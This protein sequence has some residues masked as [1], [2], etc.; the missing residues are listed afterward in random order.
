M[1]LINVSSG[2]IIHSVNDSVKT[3]ELVIKG[4]ISIQ[5]S[6]Q[7]VFLEKGSLIGLFETPGENYTGTYTAE[8]DSCIYSYTY[9]DMES[10]QKV[11]TVN[12]KLSPMLAE[13]TVD[14][15]LDLYYA[16]DNFYR[17]LEVDYG[18][19]SG[20]LDD[21][22]VLAKR[23]D[24]NLKTFP[25]L[26][27][28]EGPE[29]D[30]LIRDWELNYLESLS[31]NKD[32]LLSSFYGLSVDIALGIII[33]LSLLSRDVLNAMKELALYQN[34]L[35]E[36][37][38]PFLMEE[39][40]VRARLNAMKNSKAPG[41]MDENGEVPL[42]KNAVDVILSYSGVNAE[43]VLKTKTDIAAF[44]NLNNRS[45]GN[46]E[47][48]KLRRELTDLFF[49]IYTPCFLKSHDDPMHTPAEVRMFLLF[50]FIDEEM[51]GADNTEMLYRIMQT[52]RPDPG[53]HVFTMYQWLGLVMD[54]IEKPS[55][56]EFEQDY[57]AYIRELHMRG[58]IDDK[59]YESRINDPR[60]R[61]S[62]EI[63]NL[64]K[65]GNKM[66]FGRMSTYQ[67]FFDRE[68]A[69]MGLERTYL[70]ASRIN[71][72]LEKLMSV[73]K[74]LFRIDEE[75]R[76]EELD[77]K[78]LGIYELVYPKI[79]LFPN[80][81]SRACLWQ[82]TG[83]KRRNTPA[84]FIMPIFL[85]EDL[86]KSLVSLLGEYRWEITKTIQGVHWNDIKDPSLT[87]DYNDYIQFYKKNRDLNQEQKEKIK[88]Q[89][90][91]AGGN[92][93]RTFVA[94]YCVYMNSESKGSPLLN[95]VVRSIFFTYC[96]FNKDIREKLK[97][98]PIYQ[99]ELNKF[100]TKTMERLRPIENTIK[101]LEHSGLEVPA[102]LTD[103][104]DFLLS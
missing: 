47:T 60:E 54:G 90:S 104:V 24:M 80:C 43:T 50:G 71:E 6:D 88:K 49:K 42:I 75:Y 93:R 16:Y 40:L 81:G 62:F 55:R 82:E 61:L 27:A 8:E 13:K 46:D 103:Q 87:S 37:E 52:Y 2:Q 72:T 99:A 38:K 65:M 95:K 74:F 7:K 4:K 67:P 51:A 79:I 59:E 76:N 36:V 102:I 3:I 31:S 10:L 78:A 66:T 26:S 45:S 89:I 1:G 23:A 73:D 29:R 58:E 63:A 48:R 18:K 30:E 32:S 77:I 21:Y 11:V 9:E 33:Q 28:M 56:N 97:S 85:S 17:N 64:F 39:E 35:K 84:R 100:E 22:P 57:D 25:D 41:Q 70:S 19:I 5:I 53:R 12:E 15:A 91:K 68:N 98:S 94:D 44:R 69:T 96:P 14:D 86:N 92:L 20:D 101:K 34:R 83:G